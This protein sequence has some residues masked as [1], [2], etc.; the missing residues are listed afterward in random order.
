M[1]HTEFDAAFN[2]LD[3]KDEERLHYAELLRQLDTP[4]DLKFINAVL[5][6][7]IETYADV[8]LEDI[9]MNDEL[10][11]YTHHALNLA[12]SLLTQIQRYP[13]YKE[14]ARAPNTKEL[15][16][17]MRGELTKNPLYSLHY[18][19]NYDNADF[20]RWLRQVLFVI[21]LL[22]Q[23]KNHDEER[24]KPYEYGELSVF[25][26][27]MTESDI[28]ISW[29]KE[30]DCSTCRNLRSFV[31]WLYEYRYYFR[32]QQKLSISDL[33]SKGMKSSSDPIQH[34]VAVYHQISD[35]IRILEIPLGH[36]K[37]RRASDPRGSEDRQSPTLI[38]LHG[39]TALE[40]DAIV[41][42]ETLPDEQDN[43]NV[44]Y[45]ILQ[46]QL[47]EEHIQ[48]GEEIYE[49]QQDETYIFAEHE[50]MES[51]IAA[52]HGRR[53]SKA[54]MRK[55]E[56]QHQY[57]ATDRHSLSNAQIYQLLTWCK[58]EKRDYT[59]AEAAMVAATAFFTASPPKKLLDTTDS[60]RVNGYPKLSLSTSSMVLPAFSVLYAS[61]G[62]ESDEEDELLA[63]SAERRE[64]H[65]PMPDALHQAFAQHSDQSGF[66]WEQTHK[67]L[68]QS[69]FCL[70]DS[71]LQ[72]FIRAQTGL[73][74]TAHQIANHLF[75]RACAMFGSACATLMFNRPAPGSQARLYYTSLPTPLIQQRY[76]ELTHKVMQDAGLDSWQ[77][78]PAPVKD[79]AFL[80]GCRDAPDES[81][82]RY[83]LSSLCNELQ[84]LRKNLLS[85]DWLRFHNRYTAYCII[86]Q[87]L[88][89]GVRPT[90][91]GFI[92]LGRMLLDAKVAIVRDKDS[93]DE[94]HTRTI[95]LHPVA[96]K[97]AEV[98]NDHMHAMLGRLHR[99]GLL[100][101]WHSA[102]QPEPF[103]FTN[104]KT[105]D[106]SYK[107]AIMPFRPRLLS[108][109]I[110]PYFTLP[111]NSNRKLLRSL[112]EIKAVPSLCI[113]ALLGHGNLGETFWHQH[114]TLSLNDIR[115]TLFPHLDELVKSLDI[116]LLQ[117]IPA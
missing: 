90:H 57:L 112:F 117:G 8:W 43:N 89:T 91:D 21:P 50:P 15:S 33:D 85:T 39:V 93:A 17:L 46:T 18:L 7:F 66:L 79:R 95:P 10:V 69:K 86:V 37:K 64:L 75:L 83:L 23:D 98:Y 56:R 41:Q 60:V 67:P 32:K 68:Q 19:L 14:F 107:V 77:C 108:Q 99:I 105:L 40:G 101:Q 109:E 11:S 63:N 12:T 52:F 22:V 103:F 25:F 47:D 24:L 35:C 9:C 94:Y 114:N 74:I 26:R 102:G 78:T 96:I 1:I 72:E 113:D 53:L 82:Y 16:A 5:K 80:I 115:L 34:A 55:L 84:T 58:K 44:L 48:A 104:T 49:Q 88:L 70:H 30:K 76:R 42:I 51:Y 4:Y 2:R 97:I 31:S 13:E 71:A 110:E 100:K 59:T 45:S 28:A 6:N 92:P 20:F 54:V 87:G 3:I 116:K 29:L 81:Q 106:D 73:D 65:L 61:S 111:P 27:Q 36:E 62:T 38:P